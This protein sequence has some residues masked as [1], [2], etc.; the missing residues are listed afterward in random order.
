MAGFKIENRREIAKEKQEFPRKIYDPDR[1]LRWESLVAS[2][3]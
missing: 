1:K 3:G 2:I